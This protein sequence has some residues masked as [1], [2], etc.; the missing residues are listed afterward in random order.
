MFDVLLLF[1]FLSLH[2]A[3]KQFKIRWLCV[4]FYIS[5][6]LFTHRWFAAP[7]YWRVI[8]KRD[9]FGAHRLLISNRQF[10][11]LLQA[12]KENTLLN[13]K[14]TSKL[15]LYIHQLGTPLFSLLTNFNGI[16]QWK[17]RRVGKMVVVGYEYGTLAIKIYFFSVGFFSTYF[18]FFL[19]GTDTLLGNF[20]ANRQD[21]HLQ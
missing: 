9:L 8:S 15:L 14:Q 6:R 10:I 2:L 16:V 19:R 4:W 5:H 12:E 17:I 13:R 3:R 11:L 20:H 7:I 1:K 21:A 18:R